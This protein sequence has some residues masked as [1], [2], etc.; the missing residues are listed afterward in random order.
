MKCARRQERLQALLPFD[1]PSAPLWATMLCCLALS[2]GGQPIVYSYTDLVARLT[3][4]QHLAL[5]PAAG[6]RCAQW[7]SYDRSSFYDEPTGQYVNWS[8]NGDGSGVIRTEGNQVV[9][10]EMQGP[11]C[12][13]R[14]WS[15]TPGSGRVRIYLD[16]TNAPTVDL[17][18]SGYLDGA[19]APFTYP[20]LVH[21]TAANGWNNY[22]PI[23]YQTSCK[24]TADADWGLYFHFTYET[25]PT[26]TQLPTFTGALSPPEAAALSHVNQFL[27]DCGSDPAGARVGQVVLTNLLTVPGNSTQFVAQLA[28]PRAI[29]GIRVKADLPAAPADYDLLRELAL[30]IHW[31]GETNPAVWSPLGDFF[32]TAPGRNAYSSLPLGC[33]TN[34]WWYC[35]WYMPF[36]AAAQIRLINEG[37][38]QL[39]ILFEITHAPLDQ[40]IA[41]LARFHAKWHRDVLLPTESGRAIDWTAL[42][43]TGAGRYVGLM[44]H[45]W[46][47]RGGWWGEGDEKFFVDGEKFPSTFGTGSEDYFGYAWSSP[48]LFRHAY[49]NQTHNDGASKGHLSVNRWHLGDSVPFQQSFEGSIEKYYSNSRPTLYAATAYWYLAPGGVDPYLPV[50]LSERVGYWTPLVNYRVPGAIEGETMTVL[51]LS[52]GTAQA[53]DMSGFPGSQWSNDAQLWWTGAQPGDLLDLALEV[54][55]AGTYRLSARFTQ[56]NDYGIVQLFL[57]GKPLGSPIDLYH[58]SVI[59]TSELDLGTHVLTAGQ[60]TFR[61]QIV[62]ANPSAVFAYMFGLDYVKLEPPLV[63]RDALNLGNPAGQ[64]AVIFSTAVDSASAT[65]TANYAINH[66]VAISNARLGSAPHTVLLQTI[67]LADSTAYTATVSNVIDVASNLLTTSTRPLEQNLNTWFR[68]DE[69]TGATAADSSLNDRSGALA[70]GAAPGYEGKIL[71]ALKFDGVGGHVRLPDGYAN[72]ATNGL[73]IAVWARPTIGGG[74]A[75]WARFADFGNGPAGDNILFGRNGTSTALTFEVYEG[76]ISGGKVTSP[77]DTLVLNQWQ[78]LAATLD[79]SGHVVLYRNGVEVASGTTAVPGVVTR[80][81]N[82]LGRSNWT[83]DSHYAGLMDDLRLYDR[84]LSPEAILALAGGGGPGD[85]DAS[86]GS[87]TLEATV[88]TTALNNALPGVL[89]VRRV[90]NTNSAVTVYNAMSGTALNAV[91]YSSLPGSLIL[92]AGAADAQIYVTPIAGSFAEPA[93]VATLTLTGG[94]GYLI[95]DADQASV[96]IQNNTLIPVAIVA[97]AAN[98]IGAVAT[99]AVDVWFSSPV[100]LPSATNLANYGLVNASGVSI[101]NASLAGRNLQVILSVSGPV[102]AEA[103]LMVRGVQGA[104]ENRGS[105]QI[106]V[107]ELV[108]PATAVVANQFQQGRAAALARS[109]DGLVQHDANLTTW[110]T[111]GGAQG[112]SDFVGL[113]YPQPQ[114]FAAL[115]VDL[116]YQFVDGGDWAAAPEVYLLNNPVD[117]DQTP[118]E[119][120]LINWTEVPGALISG[121]VFDA[122]V[123]APTGTPPP[124]SPIVFDLS[125]LPYP[126]RTGYGWAVGGVAGDGPAAQF[127]SVA[128]LRAFGDPLAEPGAPKLVITITGGQIVIPWPSW[129]GGYGLHSSAQLWPAASW[130]PVSA[131]PQLAG[132]HYQVTLPISGSPAWYLLAK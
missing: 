79:G 123:D 107:F 36:A 65:N 50:P 13:W 34:G 63:L 132:D 64:V 23:P 86:L 18:F 126:Q 116:G 131:T 130:S 52:A 67:G 104:G 75:N 61:A 85:A 17:P 21:T 24:V 11:G 120:D 7:S 35:Y 115:Q 95:G 29:T 77:G 10:A 97:T 112:L 41:Q 38:N 114:V 81:A 105:N 83:G 82:F 40:P 60:H 3:N 87:V 118:P 127:V 46:N 78:H 62:G 76:G 56:A 94:A 51:G 113:T 70:A 119:S 43:T 32:G 98:A 49:H 88:P 27:L 80:T 90:G 12:I 89:T 37:T 71:R 91:N 22:V 44:L 117:T 19:N 68:F 55:T 106:P 72:F 28:G 47:P 111:F 16:G 42:K 1:S 45:V 14:I 122:A 125:R 66:G 128:E 102:P 54:A 129:A 100:T 4:L 103:Q 74:A 31:D 101:I 69:T 20:A 109:T 93:R 96:T 2:A 84:V 92:P 59:A 99:N 124:N 48:T 58:P 110:T 33:G 25:F 53:Q 26:N 39:P 73:T 121:N 6:E 9:L 5:L 8:A 108:T 30:Q 15:A 57:D